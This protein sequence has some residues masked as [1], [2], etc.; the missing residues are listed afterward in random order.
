[1]W[2]L[3]GGHQVFGTWPACQPARRGVASNVQTCNRVVTS[4]SALRAQGEPAPR[5]PALDCPG[6]SLARLLA[7]MIEWI[8]EADR[9]W[10]S[11]IVWAGPRLLG[12][13]QPGGIV[14]V[15]RRRIVVVEDETP[16]RR[17]IVD[18]LEMAGYEPVQAADGQAGLDEGRRLGVDLVLLDLR[19]PKMD[20][21]QVL[22]ELRKTHPNLPIIILTAR[23]SEEDRVNGLRKGADDY[24]VKPFSAR[25]LLARIEALLRRSAER[26][27]PV[28]SISAAGHT[29]NLERREIEFADGTRSKLS[30]MESAILV[31]LAANARRVVSRD[32][33]LSCVWGISGDTLE[34]R[35]VDMHI[36]RLRSKL[37][38]PETQPQVEWLVT[39]R[40]KGY[41]LG[42][43]VTTIAQA[44]AE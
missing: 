26:P 5:Q 2:E 38:P 24:V 31:H 41:M 37:T 9:R 33:L 11:A 29:I 39:V 12:R 44:S 18:M 4:S 27:T 20:G 30:E 21:V 22:V 40:G 42:S 28:K 15:K 32:E 3:V 23:G 13:A 19:L 25:E 10:G 1:M 16:I 17:G 6:P 8:R 34:T 14:R 7:D 36:T 35:A 43:D